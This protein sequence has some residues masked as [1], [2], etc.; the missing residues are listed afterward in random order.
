MINEEMYGGGLPWTLHYER[1]YRRRWVGRM[2]ERKK[3]T[4]WRRESE[5]LKEESET[6]LLEALI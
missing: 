2:G 1:Y 6:F 5:E 3:K 4:G